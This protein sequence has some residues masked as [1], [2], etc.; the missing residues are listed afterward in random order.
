MLPVIII[1]PLNLIGKHKIRVFQ[2]NGNESIDGILNKV[3]IFLEFSEFYLRI[4]DK[5]FLNDINC[6]V[7]GRKPRFTIPGKI[8]TH[9]EKIFWFVL[10]EDLNIFI[11]I[12]Q[13]VFVLFCFKV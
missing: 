5:K 8:S 12:F 1:L 3:V 7:H 13:N 6:G 2:I 10:I 9:A 4:S 11:E